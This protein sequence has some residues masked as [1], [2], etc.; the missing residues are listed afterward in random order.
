MTSSTSKS[1][2]GKAPDPKRLREHSPAR[3]ELAITAPQPN[4][5]DASAQ[6][7]PEGLDRERAGPTTPAKRTAEGPPPEDTPPARVRGLPTFQSDDF[8][9]L[10][11]ACPTTPS[12]GTSVYIYR[13][14]QSISLRKLAAEAM[15]QLRPAALDYFQ[16]ANCLALTFATAEERT[17]AVQ[18]GLTVDDVR[19]PVT[20]VPA[21]HP[22]LMKLT[23]DRVPSGDKRATT[24]A[25][26]TVLADWGRV[27]EV[28]PIVWEGTTVS[29]NTWYV[30]MDVAGK[31]ADHH[32]PPTVHL[33]GD[34]ILI[35]IPGVCRVRRNCKSTTHRANCRIGQR[36]DEARNRRSS[37]ET[38]TAWQTVPYKQ[39]GNST[40][41]PGLHL[42]KNQ[43]KK[44]AKKQRHQKTGSSTARRASPTTASPTD[45]AITSDTDS[46]DDT[47]MEGIHVPS[48]P[49]GLYASIHAPG[50]SPDQSEGATPTTNT[51]INAASGSRS[52]S[53]SIPSDDEVFILVE[54]PRPSVAQDDNM[55][56][57]NMADTTASVPQSTLQPTVVIPDSTPERRTWAS[58]VG[59]AADALAN[60]L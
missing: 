39:V 44:L 21:N 17:K 56:E 29:T 5:E 50:N 47:P 15:A 23:L 52:A 20:L 48:Q 14:N 19:F 11:R 49:N 26:R 12:P 3:E 40:L 7:A 57:V 16:Y 34:D 43:R 41:P 54:E 60:V 35:D 24:D 58:V 2:T 33:F 38:S 36:Q 8:A 10:Q 25:I 37:S 22:K 28:L 6:A 53:L 31:P 4:P 27:V 59:A 55:V 45:A 9:S 42:S 32:P 30:T 46:D 18:T 1:T 13:E 51:A